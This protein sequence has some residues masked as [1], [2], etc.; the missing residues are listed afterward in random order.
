MT[1]SNDGTAQIWDV[2]SQQPLGEPLRPRGAGFNRWSFG[3]TERSPSRRK[4]DSTV[5]LWDLRTG[6]V[7]GEPIPYHPGRRDNR[8]FR[9]PACSVDGERILTTGSWT[10]GRQ[11]CAQV[12]DATKGKPLGA[13]LCH[14]RDIRSVALSRDG[15]VAMTGSECRRHG[16]TL[17]RAHG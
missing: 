5:R 3:P 14:D 16:S 1:G 4:G 8:A 11:E 12:W 7:I 17:G 15:K 10:S 9:R 2:A 6:Q 13:P